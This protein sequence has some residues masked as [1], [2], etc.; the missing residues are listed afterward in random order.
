[1]LGLVILLVVVAVLA[2]WVI[3]IYNGLI[4][5]RRGYENAFAQIDVQLTRR[6]DL[7]PNLV[8]TAKG[9]MAHERETLEAVIQA[10]NMAMSANSIEDKAAAE[11]VITGALKSVFALSEAYPDLK[12]I[13]GANEPTAVGMGRALQQAGFKNAGLPVDP[14]QVK[15]LETKASNAPAQSAKAKGG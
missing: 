8:E 11:N 9:Y 6:Y 10:R 7:I 5:A 1:M 12:G 2:F 4:R 14:N 3:G 13:F 15:R